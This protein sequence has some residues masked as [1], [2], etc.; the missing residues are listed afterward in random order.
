MYLIPSDSM[1]LE[2]LFHLHYER[3]DL[4][5]EYVVAMSRKS[6]AKIDNPNL[7]CLAE[8]EHQVQEFSNFLGL[9]N[10]TEKFLSVLEMLHEVP[11][12]QNEND[13][14]VEAARSGINRTANNKKCR[15]LKKTNQTR[16]IQRDL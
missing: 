10:D 7:W 6:K 9:S 2:K 1:P 13:R 4:R 14:R 15:K 16:R 5:H 12:P 8:H 11:G 3:R